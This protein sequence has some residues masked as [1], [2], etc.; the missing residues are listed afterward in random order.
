MHWPGCH[1]A[2]SPSPLHWENCEWVIEIMAWSPYP[3]YYSTYSLL[4][5]FPSRRSLRFN[6]IASLPISIFSA[7]TSLRSL[8]ELN[9]HR[10]FSFFLFKCNSTISNNAFTSL[11]TGLLNGLTGLKHLYVEHYDDHRHAY[12]VHSDVA[13]NDLTHIDSDF[14]WPATYLHKINL[15]FNSITSLPVDMLKYSAQLQRLYDLV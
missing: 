4:I 2:S 15:E 14:F 11:S 5:S 10:N 8:F 12:A 6:N 9:Q 3:L 13:R 7:A 1:R